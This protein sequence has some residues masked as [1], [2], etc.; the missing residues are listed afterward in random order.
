MNDLSNTIAAGLIH[1]FQDCRQRVHAMA[2]QLSEEQF[3]LKP[4]SYGNSFGALVRHLT[5][6]LNYYIGAQIARTGYIRERELEFTADPSGEKEQALAGLDEALNMVIDTLKEQTEP[7]WDREYDAA[8]SD[9]KDRF[10]I[11]LDCSVHFRHHIGQMM[12]LVQELTKEGRATE[13]QGTQSPK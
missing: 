3:W 12:Y 8:K 7:D 6:N 11:F 9:A 5:G 10:E 1:S 13:A 2:Q 4:F